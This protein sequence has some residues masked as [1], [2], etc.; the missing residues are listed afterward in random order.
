MNLD[1]LL[2]PQ[3]EHTKNVLDSIYLNGVGFDSSETGCGKTFCAA[4]I[5]KNL[6]CPIIVICPKSIITKWKNTLKLFGVTPLLVINWEKLARGNT[7]NYKFKKKEYMNAKDWWRSEGIYSNFPK[8]ALI[9]FDEAHRGRGAKSRNGEMMVALKNHGYRQ[10]LLSASAAT[11]ATEMRNFGYV[12]NLHN[13]E[14]FTTF[15]K[16]HGAKNDGYGGL[17]WDKDAPEAVAGM[18]KIHNTLYTETMIA[19]HMNRKDFGDIFPDNQ[20]MAESFDLGHEG[21]SKLQAIYDRMEAE[22]ASLDERSKDYSSHTFAIMMKARR[23]SELLKVPITLEWIIDSYDEGISPV[24]FFNFIDSLEAVA[25]RLPK[26]LKFGKI[27]G[28]QSGPIRDAQLDGFQ[29][30]KLRCML[31]NLAAGSDAIDLHD[32]HG[33]YPRHSLICPSWSPTRTLQA[34]GRIHRAGGQTPCVQK[35]LFASEIEERQRV[36]IHAKLTN[37][38]ILNYGDLS[39]IEGIPLFEPDF[40]FDP[41]LEG[42]LV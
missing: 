18:A 24:V 8:N 27:V 15:A 31:A 29:S 39:L 38:S 5:A 22:I 1:N 25:A 20:I 35:F 11:T 3:K 41:D 32:T 13:G 28:G 4:S 16:D 42:V 21:S 33:N 7:P 34:L 19:H 23:Q 10:L 2:E 40:E 12:T 37:L 14:H 36:R 9:I 6:N 26:H 30:D 17:M